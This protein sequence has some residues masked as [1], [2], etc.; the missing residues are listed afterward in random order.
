MKCL[1]EAI[2]A[3]VSILLGQ[4]HAVNVK[5]PLAS[6]CRVLVEQKYHNRLATKEAH[7]WK[8]GEIYFQDV[9]SYDHSMIGRMFDRPKSEDDYKTF[10]SKSF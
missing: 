8:R 2:Q 7:F 1:I 9:P 4:E 10:K 3:S 5:E 6:R